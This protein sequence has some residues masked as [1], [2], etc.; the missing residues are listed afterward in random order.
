MVAAL[1]HE[2]HQVT[3]CG[4]AE[5]ARRLLAQRQA[6]D[7]LFTDVMMT[8]LE[9]V[10]WCTANLPD[11]PALVATG[12]T[13][14][15]PYGGVEGLAQAL[16]HRGPARCARRVRRR[17]GDLSA[18]RQDIARMFPQRWRQRRARR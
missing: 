3:L 10:E 8:G 14:R 2:G 4:T 5:E 7:V 18:P 1:E 9:L 6:A 13:A 17:G 15:S 11:V 12:Y 16:S